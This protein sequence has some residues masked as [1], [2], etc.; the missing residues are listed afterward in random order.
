M[1][2]WQLRDLI[3]VPEADHCLYF[4]RG[5]ATRRLHTEKGEVRPGHSKLPLQQT[6]YVKS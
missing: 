4:V 2:H 6:V 5:G 3:H 1:Q